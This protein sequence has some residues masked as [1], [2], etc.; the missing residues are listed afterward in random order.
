MTWQTHPTLILDYLKKSE[1][2]ELQKR[3][4]EMGMLVFV[5]TTLFLSSVNAWTGEIRGRVVCDVCGDSS[6]G[7]EDHVLEG[8]FLAL[9]LS[10]CGFM[11]L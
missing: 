8:L 1:A 9:S 4:L 11:I 5:L 3:K 6:I 10:L 2:M 7:P